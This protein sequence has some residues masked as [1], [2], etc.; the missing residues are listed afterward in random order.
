MVSSRSLACGCIA[1]EVLDKSSQWLSWLRS[2][3]PMVGLE[4]VAVGPRA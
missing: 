4:D 2:T 3:L 1:F